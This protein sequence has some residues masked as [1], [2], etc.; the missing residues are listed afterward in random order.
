MF[1]RVT[2]KSVNLNK[3]V[4]RISAAGPGLFEHKQP[5]MILA[6]Q[7]HLD[8]ASRFAQQLGAGEVQS[9]EQ[10]K[11]MVRG[12]PGALVYL[13]GAESSEEMLTAL[14]AMKR[15]RAVHMA[16]FLA[17]SSPQSVMRLGIQVG[18][19]R[20]FTG[21]V[22]F[23]IE[24]VAQALDLVVPGERVPDLAALRIQLELTQA[25]LAT[26]LGVTARTVQ[27]WEG[28]KGARLMLRRTRELIELINGLN[29]MVPRQLQS[30]WLRKGWDDFGGRS[31]RDLILAGKLRDIVIVFERA[32]EGQ[33]A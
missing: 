28:G 10:L 29:I 32:S 3:T 1:F 14:Q 2:I 7:S 20:P 33:P 18:R 19:A 26:A 24:E 21:K 12:V 23:K 30:E 8:A 15:L 9:I 27:N 16:V 22:C 13:D 25:E 4:D 11:E 31:P 5:I 17:D 6:W